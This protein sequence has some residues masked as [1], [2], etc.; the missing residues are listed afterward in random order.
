VKSYNANGGKPCEPGAAREV[1]GCDERICGTPLYCGWGAWQEWGSCSSLCGVGTRERT[2]RL[3]VSSEKPPASLLEVEND[4]LERQ[5]QESSAFNFQHLL[6]A[7]SAGAVSLVAV[8]GV[9]RLSSILMAA[10]GQTYRP[11]GGPID[12]S[13]E[14]GSPE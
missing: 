8:M 10:R 4:D 6:L 5:F 3:E 1:A 13:L 2:R 11:V 14:I 7:W 12:D 9:F